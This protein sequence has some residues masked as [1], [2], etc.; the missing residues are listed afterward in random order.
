[1]SQRTAVTIPI[2]AEQRFNDLFERHHADVFRYCV[3]RLNPA[4]AE[5]MAA[6]VFAVAWRRLDQVPDTDMAKAW[7][8][9][10]AYRV[11]GNQYRGRARRGRL[12]A[13]LGGLPPEPPEAAEVVVIR[14]EEEDAVR[15]ALLAL[16]EGDRELLR[17]VSWDGLSH[18]EIGDVLGIAEDTVSKRVSRAQSR[19]RVAYDHLYPNSPSATSTE[20]ST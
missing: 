16:R 4:D 8:L 11:V 12:F 17:L 6:E 13:R 10:V 7:L 15:R 20:A 5:D 18:R 3:R 1:M 2:D 19:L 9:A 14:R